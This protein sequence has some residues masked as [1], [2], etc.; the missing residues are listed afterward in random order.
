MISS[1]GAAASAR[2]FG[3]RRVKSRKYGAAPVAVVCCSRISE[4]QTR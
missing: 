3:Q 1:I 2:T 4:S